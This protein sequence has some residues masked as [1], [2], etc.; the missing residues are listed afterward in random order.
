MQ[1]IEMRDHRTFSH[2]EMET[3]V[4]LGERN[5]LREVVIKWEAML[6]W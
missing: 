4:G 5:R 6:R 3:G 1:L 2:E